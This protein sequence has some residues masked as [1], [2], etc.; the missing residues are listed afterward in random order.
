[1]KKGLFIIGFLVL[2]FTLFSTL[3]SSAD[4]ANIQNAFKPIGDL[5]IAVFNETTRVLETVFTYILGNLGGTPDIFA[6][7]VLMFLVV[8]AVI[9]ALSKKMPFLNNSPTWQRVIIAGSIGVLGTR[10]LDQGFIQG[11]ILSNEGTAVVITNAIP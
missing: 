4:S 7:R 11:L 9:Y 5:V 10:F 1:M 3:V 2:S 8:Y 6:A